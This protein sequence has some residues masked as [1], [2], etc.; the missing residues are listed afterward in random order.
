MNYK[1]MLAKILSEKELADMDIKKIK[2][3][4]ALLEELG[5]PLAVAPPENWN[6]Y[7]YQEELYK[8]EIDNMHL[9][10]PNGD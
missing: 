5:I 7:W 8:K 10:D 4:D 3:D 1:V 2:E 9:N 6:P